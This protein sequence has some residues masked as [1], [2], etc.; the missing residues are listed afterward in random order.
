MAEEREI[1]GWYTRGGKHIP[2]FEN[3]NSEWDEDREN[4]AWKVIDRAQMT[5]KPVKWDILYG[6]MEELLEDMKNTTSDPTLPAYRVVKGYG[7]INSFKNVLEKGGKLSE[8]QEKQLK[9]LAPEIF[10]NVHPRKIKD[11]SSKTFADTSSSSTKIEPLQLNDKNRDKK[12]D[13]LK[14]I[15]SGIKADSRSDAYQK[16]S[17]KLGLNV[18]SHTVLVKSSNN[19]VWGDYIIDITF[20]NGKVKSLYVQNPKDKKDVTFIPIK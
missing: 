14:S 18:G 13:A 5:N 20:K 1:K 6:S 9:K 8:A 15:V 19:L 7:Y 16:L 12:I 3:S 10:K 17:E 2:I 4:L 11:G